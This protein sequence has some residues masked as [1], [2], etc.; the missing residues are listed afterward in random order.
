MS[1][2]LQGKTFAFRVEGFNG[3]F[4]LVFQFIVLI[5]FQARILYLNL[6]E[7]VVVVLETVGG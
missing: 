5:F 1:F 6:G 7:K 4:L 2:L 3:C